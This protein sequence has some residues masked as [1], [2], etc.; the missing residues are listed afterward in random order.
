MTLSEDLRPLFQ[1]RHVAVIGASRTPGRT[2]YNVVSNLLACGFSGRISP[3]NPAGGDVLGI[4]CYASLRAA[5]RDIDCAMMVIPADGAVAAMTDCAEAGVRSVIIGASGFAEIATEAG[6]QRQDDIARIAR[7]SGIRVIGPNTNGIYN[8]T[9]GISLGFNAE[10]ADRIPPGNISFVSHSGALFGGTVR[11]LRRL[12]LGFSKFVTVGNESDLTILDILEYLIQDP[13][14]RVIGMIVEGLSDGPRLRMLASRAAAEEKAIVALKVGRSAVGAGAALAHSSRLAGKARAFDALFHASGIAS[15]RSI[16][17]LASGCA[18]LARRDSRATV[19]DQSLVCVTTSGA[20]GALLADHAAERGIILAGNA[21]GEWE[22]AAAER[23]AAI[24]R[25]GHLR[26]PIDLGSLTAHWHR[27]T[28]VMGVLEDEGI[29]GPLAIFAHGA[30]RPELGQQLIEVAAARKARAGSLVV[31]IAPGGLSDDVEASYRAHGIPVFADIAT[32]MDSLACH[33]ATLPASR[34]DASVAVPDAP[35]PLTEE[36][37]RLTRRGLW[38]EIESTALLRRAGIPMVDSRTVMSIQA[39]EA[40]A[41]EFGFPVVI[42]AIA[43]D[44][45]HKNDRG[46]VVVGIHDLPALRCQ[47]E[48]LRGRIL[49]AGYGDDVPIIMQPMLPAKAEIL[50]G[51]SEEPGLGHFLVFGLGGTFTEVFDQAALLPIPSSREAIRS[52]ISATAVGRMFAARNTARGP[53]IDQIID[54]LLA[55]QAIAIQH[56]EWIT[57]IEI[58]PLLITDNGCFG[59]DGLIVTRPPSPTHDAK[60][61]SRIQTIGGI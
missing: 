42:K 22:G 31:V 40:A 45:A 4:P 55:L 14:T 61:S 51:V 28:D 26:N 6:R 19:G 16:E 47:Y 1:P 44:V 10:H 5:P 36:E 48:E 32:G 60:A 20:G 59:V 34:I 13:A 53:A 30:A 12:G 35:T 23:I 37:Q 2:G 43:P 50:L 54:A 58:N 52:G 33:Y 24:P 11:T 41:G 27:A 17:A 15:V 18:L 21:Q 3:I 29:G 8:A 56:R 57:S 38:P 39:A 46:F 25:S 7:E 9:D 49:A